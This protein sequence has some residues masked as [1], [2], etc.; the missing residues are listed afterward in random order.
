MDASKERL[1]AEEDDGYNNP[2][3]ASGVSGNGSVKQSSKQE[4]IAPCGS[5]ISNSQIHLDLTNNSTE[6]N[7]QQDLASVGGASNMGNGGGPEKLFSL[8]EESSV[9]EST[10]SDYSIPFSNVSK[11]HSE[12]DYIS[13]H[14]AVQNTGLAYNPSICR[15]RKRICL[16]EVCPS[17][18]SIQNGKDLVQKFY[19]CITLYELLTRLPKHY[20]LV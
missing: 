13:S 11:S 5:E 15:I 16:T 1:T 9:H 10:K 19:V 3:Q 4:T 18:S 7:T 6:N 2:L 17:H 12:G 8:I 14:H 20:C